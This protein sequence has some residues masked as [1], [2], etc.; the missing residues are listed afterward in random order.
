MTFDTSSFEFAY[1]SFLNFLKTIFAVPGEVFLRR[2]SLWVSENISP[3]DLLPV[4]HFSY[5]RL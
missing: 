5:R 3:S 1:N 2:I 4:V